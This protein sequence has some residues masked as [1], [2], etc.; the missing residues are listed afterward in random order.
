[1][2]KV[3]CSLAVVLVLALPI[4]IFAQETTP[5]V[6]LT[7]T[8]EAYQTANLR[9]GADTRYPIVGRLTAG[10]G[11][12][13]IGR[14]AAGR[15]L[16][17]ETEEGLV[18]WLPAYALAFAGELLDIPLAE[19]NLAEAGEDVFVTAYGLI[20]LRAEPDM[21]SVLVGQLDV[22]DTAQATAR[23]CITN[24]WLLIRFEPTADQPDRETL[25]GWVA[26][27]TVTV[28][29]DV[30]ALPVLVPGE[31]GVSLIP[32]SALVQ[33]AF[34]A[35]LH[36]EATEESP[37]LIIVPFEE[38]VQ[39]LGRSADGLWLYV[40]YNGVSGWGSADL[41]FMRQADIAELPVIEE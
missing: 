18:G 3:A 12:I 17:V 37:V 6:T 5:E 21:D 11:V 19:E 25:E 41:F 1:M 32:P 2:L 16:L 13:I 33:A 23:C 39:P 38:L 34:N 30:S 15:W 31:D 4:A 14:D 28:R 7:L 36:P 29:G 26:Y 27:F 35:R 8:A 22:G 9:A 40:A 24:D 20:N 10:D